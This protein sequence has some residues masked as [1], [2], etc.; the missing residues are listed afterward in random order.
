MEP[1]VVKP[2]EI[3]LFARRLLLRQLECHKFPELE[4]SNQVL[5][6]IRDTIVNKVHDEQHSFGSQVNSAEDLTIR[7]INSYSEDF[8]SL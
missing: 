5:I 8:I 2:E 7:Q 4:F 3:Q 6:A 1:E